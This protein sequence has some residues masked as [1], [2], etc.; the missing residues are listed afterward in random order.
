MNPS[1][2]R[3]TISAGP[4]AKLRFA[5]QAT[6]KARDHAFSGRLVLLVLD[7]LWLLQ[8]SGIALWN[9]VSRIRKTAA[10]SALYA[11]PRR[12]YKRWAA[13]LSLQRQKNRLYG[14]LV[15]KTSMTDSGYNVHLRTGILIHRNLWRRTLEITT[16]SQ[17][18]TILHSSQIEVAFP[19]FIAGQ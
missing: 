5:W 2:E 6:L 12:L 16:T 19:G 4:K 14:L 11:A 1:K 13:V 18:P 9:V 10:V 15:R 3:N 7:F 8:R 17:S